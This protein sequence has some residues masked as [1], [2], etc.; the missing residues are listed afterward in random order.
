MRAALLAVKH[1]RIRRNAETHRWVR[2]LNSDARQEVRNWS[3]SRSTPRA[4]PRLAIGG[5]DAY[6]FPWNHE[7]LSVNWLRTSRIPKYSANR[8]KWRVI[9]CSSSN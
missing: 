7:R 3:E 8:R 5:R 9:A 4:G 1:P 6:I 2:Q